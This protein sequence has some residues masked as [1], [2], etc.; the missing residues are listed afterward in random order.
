MLKMKGPHTV[1]F[2][3]PT[4]IGKTYFALDLLGKE[5]KN[6]FD[7]ITI[8]CP[9]LKHNVTYSSRKWFW[10]GSEVILVESGK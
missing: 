3:A 10:T 4:G 5:Y 7:F 1:L 6:Y 2:V 9:T 8:T